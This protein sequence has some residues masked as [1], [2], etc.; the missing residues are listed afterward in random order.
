PLGHTTRASLWIAAGKRLWRGLRGGFCFEVLVGWAV[1][2]VRQRRTLARLAFAGRRAAP[3]DAAV[4]RT[5]LD[6][7][8]DEVRGGLDSLGDRPGHVRLARD[9]EVAPDVLEEGPVG[10]REIERVVGEP[11]HRVLAGLEDGPARLEL[12]LAVA[13]RVDHVLD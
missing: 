9:R 3:G 8:L 5:G 10:L 13:V 7:L 1:V 2:A 4:E 12:R 11:L 6:L